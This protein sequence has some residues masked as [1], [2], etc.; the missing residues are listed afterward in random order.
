MH[1]CIPVYTHVLTSCARSTHPMHF[2]PSQLISQP[3]DQNS[4]QEFSHINQSINRSAANLK[5]VKY[6]LDMYTEEWKIDHKLPRFI[7]QIAI[8]LRWNFLSSSHELERMDTCTP[9]CMHT[10]FHFPSH[11]HFHSH[12]IIEFVFSSFHQGPRHHIHPRVQP[13]RPG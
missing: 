7:L 6:I 3:D 5:D 2:N 13:Y 9:D 4:R 8:Q 10:D 12:L 1:P 11:F